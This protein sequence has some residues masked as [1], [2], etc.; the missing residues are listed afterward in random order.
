MAKKKNKK[1]HV[2]GLN[3]EYLSLELPSTMEDYQMWEAYRERKIIFN[4]DVDARA[5][6]T[7]VHW[8]IK[9]NE[10]DDKNKLVGDE[11]KKIRIFITSNGGDVVAGFAILDAIRSSKTLVETIAIGCAAS[12]GV[13]LLMGGHIRKAYP[14][15]VLL[16]HDGSLGAHGTS[17]KVKSTMAFYDKLDQRVKKFILDHTKISEELYDAKADVEWYLFADPDGIELGIVDELI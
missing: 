3:E 12:M 10:E 8:I 4:D 5:V 1:P 13:L 7:I 6:N 15:T 17:N 11:R 16:I 9:W 14:N 2:L